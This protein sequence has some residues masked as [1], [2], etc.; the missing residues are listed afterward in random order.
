MGYGVPYLIISPTALLSMIGLAIGP[1][2][3]IPTPKENWKD[4]IIDVV[5]PAYN[6]EKN[7]VLALATLSEQT[8]KLRQIYVCD[9]GSRDATVLYARKFSESKNIPCTVLTKEKSEGKTA[10]LKQVT[11]NSDSD[12]LFVLDGDT[13]LRSENYIETVVKELY[14]GAGIASACGNVL[15][16]MKKDKDRIIN[17]YNRKEFEREYPKMMN[18][19]QSWFDKI[20]YKLSSYYR[21]EL[22][23]YLEKFIYHGEMVFFGTIVNPIGC[24]VAYRRK[25]LQEIFDAYEADLGNNLT[26][27]EDIFLGFAFLNAGYKNV[28]TRSVY[29]LTQEPKI[30]KLPVQIF[31]WSS[32]FMQC[33]YYFNDLVLSPFKIFKVLYKKIKEKYSWDA[34]KHQE[35]RKI[36]EAYRQ[37]FG[38]QITEK[39]SRPI[40]WYIFTAVFEKCCFPFILLMLMYFGFWEMLAYTVMA[41]IFVYSFL[42]FSFHNNANITTLFKSIMFSPLR[43]IVLLFDIV[44]IAGFI[45]DIYFQ[46]NREWTK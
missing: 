13:I 5:I 28:M 27:S 15:P 7:I 41:E 39:Y 6:E 9:D 35:M 19:Y 44:I 32:S 12:V 22:Y 43:Y 14:Q 33:C 21:E 1:D 18:V 25:N 16:L 11:R 23:L 3:T 8:Q 2:K 29:A 37:A 42:V 17:Q 26:T 45:K 24:A 31:K 34:N 4:V 40:G 36:K 46:D 30:F 20:Q 38:A 10:F